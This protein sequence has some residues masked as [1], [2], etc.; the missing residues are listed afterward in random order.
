[1]QRKANEIAPRLAG[2][3]P[4]ASLAGARSQLC[5]ARTT[6]LL[7]ICR[8]MAKGKPTRVKTASCFATIKPSSNLPLP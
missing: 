7:S 3:I 4:A 1:M 2:S 8:R 5:L 6:D